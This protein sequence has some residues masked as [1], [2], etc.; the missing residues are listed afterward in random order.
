M[1]RPQKS[2]SGALGVFTA[3]LA[4]VMSLFHLYAA[5]GVM[6]THVLR[7]I[8]VAFILFLGFLLFP[9]T[10]RFRHRI[11]WWD[12]VAAFISLVI[13]CNML[14][15]GDEWWFMG[16]RIYPG[17]L[18]RSERLAFDYKV[19]RTG[20]AGKTMFQRGDT[21]YIKQNGEIVAKQ[22]STSIPCRA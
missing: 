16:P 11:C 5:Y 21:T 12:W 7:G 19:A 3:G 8:H 4:V 22:R 2:R 6:P 15:G 14:F 9:V 18:L 13:V 20:F 17:D 1:I 10:K